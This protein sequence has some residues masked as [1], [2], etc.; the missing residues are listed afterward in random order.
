V[1]R[2]IVEAPPHAL[3]QRIVAMKQRGVGAL[4]SQYADALSIDKAHRSV[5]LTGH[6]WHRGTHTVDSHPHGS[7]VTYRVSNIAR[8]ARTLA[9]VQRPLYAKEMR[10]DFELMLSLIGGHDGCLSETGRRELLP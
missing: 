10:C 7:L 9:V 5:T 1:L 4:G 2:S 6:W 3:F 8:V